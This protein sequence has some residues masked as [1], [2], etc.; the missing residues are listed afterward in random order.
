MQTCIRFCLDSYRPPSI[1]SHQS[2]RYTSPFS[3]PPGYCD[4]TNREEG[5][6]T[7]QPVA[8]SG[9]PYPGTNTSEYFQTLPFNRN[10]QTEAPNINVYDVELE[11]IAEG[12][13]LGLRQPFE[14]AGNH[15]VDDVCD[16]TNSRLSTSPDP[17]F[18]APNAGA[19]TIRRMGKHVVDMSR[20]NNWNTT[21]Y[22]SMSYLPGPTY[23]YTD[24]SHDSSSHNVYTPVRVTPQHAAYPYVTFSPLAQDDSG[25]CLNSNRS[26][27][28]RRP[29]EGG[30]HGSYANQ[31]QAADDSR[32]ALLPTS[33]CISDCS[34]N[35]R[36][37]D[38]YL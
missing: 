4:S 28:F 18:V 38:L 3:L 36:T 16:L 30:Y 12:V 32:T 14:G 21:K 15:D 35:E 8:T 7:N 6:V 26:V 20:G 5:L 27:V 37:R 33:S 19:A 9:E 13:P 29:P 2:L 10:R 1:S 34:F 11:T 22:H 24:I 17:R 23:S 31:S 25:G